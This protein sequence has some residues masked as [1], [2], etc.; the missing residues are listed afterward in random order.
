MFEARGDGKMNSTILWDMEHEQ[1]LDNLVQGISNT[2]IFRTIGFIGDSLSSGEFESRSDDG[3]PGYHDYYEYSWGQYI[4]RKNG[5]TAHSFSRGGMSAKEFLESFAEQNDFWN[6]EK[7]CQAYVI[8]LG[9]ND[10]FGLHQAIGCVDDICRE[11]RTRNKDTFAGYYG[12]VIQR[13][14]EIQPQAKFFLLTM[15]REED[16]RDDERQ[17]MAELLYAM[18]DFFDNTYVIDLFKYAPVYDDEFKKRY[19]LYGHLNASGY[20]LTANMVDAYIDYLVRH[21]PDDFRR[22]PFIGKNLK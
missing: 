21:H 16:E 14:K 17:A 13:F 7:A 6:P 11:D 8:A 3:T 18:A 15:P 20:I 2:A 5:L 22:V 10:L 19:Y 4:A 9:V 1:P 12:A